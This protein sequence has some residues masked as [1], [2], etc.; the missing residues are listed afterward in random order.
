M[1][2]FTNNYGPCI[3]AVLSGLSD[4]YAANVRFNFPSY[5]SSKQLEGVKPQVVGLG[6]PKKSVAYR[7]L[8]NNL[9]QLLTGVPI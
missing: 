9:T 6:S 2:N 8:A 1:T 7:K 5:I 3:S 4:L